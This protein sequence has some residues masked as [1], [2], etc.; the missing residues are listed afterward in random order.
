MKRDILYI[1]I[2][3][4][5]TDI[6]IVTNIPF[7]RQS[8]PFLFFSIV[9]GYLLVKGFNIRLIEKFSLSVGLSLA[10]IMLTGLFVNSLYPLVLRPLS[11]V[12]LLVSLN[13]LVLILLFFCFRKTGDISFSLGKEWKSVFSHP[14]VFFPLFLPIL[15]VLGSY[16]MNIYSINLILLFMLISIPVYILILAME[17]DKV[18]PFVYPITLYC[19]GFS[20][21]ALNILPSNYIIGRDIHMEY[22][23][24]KTSLLN[25]HWDIH[26]PYHSYNSCLSITILPAIYK[27]LLGVPPTLIFK[28]YYLLIGAIVPVPMYVFARRILKSR[29]FAFY[30]TLLLMFQFAYTY[31]GQYARQLIAFLFFATAIMTLTIPIKE[32]YK[33]ILFIIFILATVFSHYTSSYVFFAV[34]A[35]PPFIIWAS[36]HLKGRF[37]FPWKYSRTFSNKNLALLFFVI[38]FLWYA[39]VTGPQFRDVS[40]VIIETFRSMANFFS[41]D[42]RNYSEQ[43]VLGIGIAHIPNFLSTFVHDV[44]FALI[45]IGVLGLFFKSEYRKKYGVSDEYIASTIVILAILASFVILPY[46]SKAYG[47]TRLFSQLLVILA[48]CFII[49]VKFIVDYAKKFRMPFEREKLMRTLILALLILGFICTNYLQYEL[50]GIPYSYAYDSGGERRYE[51]FIYDSEVTGAQWLNNYGNK[52]AT[53]HTDRVGDH[54]ILLGFNKKPKTD[55]FFFNNTGPFQKGDYIYLRHLNINEELVFKDTP[56]RPPRFINGRL[57]MDNV[58]PLTKY[59]WLLTDKS[60]IYDNGGSMILFG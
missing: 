30:A 46:V 4:I 1:L 2:L 47:G 36:K 29:E 31:M 55:H 50:F 11:L 38:I 41:L 57:E 22:Y 39:Q 18:H 8:L 26:D 28:F 42:L 17:R 58:E 19:I 59:F 35:I 3:L 10:F 21:L 14:I 15:T 6:S 53:I 44:I 33:K 27:Y 24:F 43:A 13:I 25:H 23:C 32:S 49:G 37:H 56:G 12:P 7:L 54:R 60:T 34:V 16:I 9:P 45:G 51:T 52:S 40:N 48:P 20:L 5:L